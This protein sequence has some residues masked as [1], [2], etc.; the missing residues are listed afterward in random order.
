MCANKYRGD[1][2]LQFRDDSIIPLFFKQLVIPYSIRQVS[3]RAAML[4][5]LLFPEKSVPFGKH[6]PGKE[7][8]KLSKEEDICYAMANWERFQASMVHCREDLH[9]SMKYIYK[10]LSI[11]PFLR[12]YTTSLQHSAS[13][14]MQQAI[15]KA[16]TERSRACI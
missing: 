16:S 11:T 6:S 4:K 8:L 12:I 7:S 15:R 10:V 3:L 2:Y 9:I 14:L 5:I 1:P 13:L